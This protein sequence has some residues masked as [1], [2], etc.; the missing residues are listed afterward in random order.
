MPRQTRKE[1]IKT[2]EQE[3][4]NQIKRKF[5]DAKISKHLRC[6]ICFDVFNDPVFGPC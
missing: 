4:S 2:E 5:V 3:K 1:K 6:C